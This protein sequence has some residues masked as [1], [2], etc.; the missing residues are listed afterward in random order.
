VFGLAIA[1]Q[2]MPTFKQGLD[3]LLRLCSGAAAVC[4]HG[5]CLHA[6]E[7]T[8]LEN[9][10]VTVA[11]FVQNSCMQTERHQQTF[12]SLSAAS[13]VQLQHMNASSILLFEQLTVSRSTATGF[14][15]VSTVEV[16]AGVKSGKADWLDAERERW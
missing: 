9:K 14:A 2:L 16:L 6:V 12:A 5:H 1:V 15:I 13:S 4:A 3:S 8:D 10:A 7:T 11:P